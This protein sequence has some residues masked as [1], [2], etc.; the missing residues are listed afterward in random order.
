MGK[1]ALPVGRAQAP[2]YAGRPRFRDV[3][4]TNEANF[5]LILILI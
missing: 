2:E 5:V 3:H 4:G 1:E